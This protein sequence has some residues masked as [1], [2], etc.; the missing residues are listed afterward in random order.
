MKNIYYADTALLNEIEQLNGAPRSWKNVNVLVATKNLALLEYQKF[1]LD[2]K[3]DDR[4]YVIS[5]KFGQFHL[6]NIIH[7]MSQNC[8]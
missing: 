7:L 5:V 8:V 6:S 4:E 1:K 2:L 3:H